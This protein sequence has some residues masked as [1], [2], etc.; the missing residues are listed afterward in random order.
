MRS[1]SDQKDIE[2]HSEIMMLYAE[3]ET[4]KNE[5]K[6]LMD[7][8]NNCKSQNETISATQ[9]EVCMYVRNY[10][11]FLQARSHILCQSVFNS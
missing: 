7:I 3:L 8:H 11:I 5:H 2:H 9:I 10:V 4:L 1:S 6:Q